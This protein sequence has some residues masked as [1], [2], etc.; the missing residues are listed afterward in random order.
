MSNASDNQDLPVVVLSAG[1]VR[2]I[3]P[4][5]LFKAL[6]RNQFR[7]R[8]HPLVVG[9]AVALRM[10]AVELW[11]AGD[12]PEMV[13]TA[14]DNIVDIAE[15]GDSELESG[16]MS[17]I[18]TSLAGDETLAGRWAGRAVELAVELIGRGAASALVTAP[19]DKHAL[20]LAGYNY[21]GHTEMLAELSGGV[22]VSMMLAGGDLRVVPATTHVALAR[23]PSLVDRELIV[24][25]CRV[26]DRGL[27]SVFG[28]T[29]PR[30]AVCGLN[31]HLGDGGVAGDEDQRITAPAVE[32]ARAAGLDV[33]GPFPADTVFVRAARGE[34]DA[35]LAMYHDQA[36]VAIKM[37]AF[38]G[39]VNVT[40]GLPF[41]RTSPDHGTALDIAGRG[42]ADESSMAHALELAVKSA[43]LENKG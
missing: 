13:R 6:A 26:I 25:Q 9:P 11:P 18:R 3:G 23:V 19:L 20:N 42:I 5:V 28:I 27:K 39:G 21:P 1:D 31:P 36:M 32:D 40:L 37:H 35:V 43:R 17:G 14:L 7:A 22:D 15:G 41:V 8:L 10:Q 4:E 24:R 16:S 33:A 30:I 12:C 34:F 29:G 38:G 2:G